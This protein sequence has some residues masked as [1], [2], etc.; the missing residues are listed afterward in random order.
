MSKQEEKFIKLGQFLKY[1]GIAESGA[2]A[3]MMIIDGQVKVNGEVDLRRGRKLHDGDQIVVAGK[4]YVYS[5]AGVE[6]L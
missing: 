6:E 5:D 2:H 1:E 3:K 4:T